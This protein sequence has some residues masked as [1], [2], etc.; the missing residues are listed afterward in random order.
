M[1][2]TFNLK[3]LKALLISLAVTL[4]PAGLSALITM[5]SMG[6]Y[7]QLIKPFFFLSLPFAFL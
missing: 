6:R 2:K 7:N 5:N 1:I 3:N 4:I